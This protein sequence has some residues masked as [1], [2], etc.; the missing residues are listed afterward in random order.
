[1]RFGLAEPKGLPIPRFIYTTRAGP[2][3]LSSLQDVAGPVDI[4]ASAPRA[5]RGPA[6]QRVRAGRGCRAGAA[7]AEGP[8]SGGAA[9]RP[10]VGAC[11]SRAG[12]GAGTGREGRAT[13]RGLR[14]TGITSY[15]LAGR[16]DDEEG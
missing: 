2:I 1:M 8:G 15:D 9:V 10:V 14:G 13:A 6:A 3:P 12:A 16:D 11:G 4:E 5:G 7:A